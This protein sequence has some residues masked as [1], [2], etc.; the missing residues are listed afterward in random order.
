MVLD[1]S[2]LLAAVFA[3]SLCAFVGVGHTLE[4]N[5]GGELGTW[6]VGLEYT[7]VQLTLGDTLVCSIPR[8]PKQGLFSL[9]RACLK[10]GGP[11]PCSEFRL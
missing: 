4:V 6:T 7:A 1:S 3:A 10:A 5:V 8:L 2:L 11:R 9:K